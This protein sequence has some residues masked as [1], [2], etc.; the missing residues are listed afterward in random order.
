MTAESTEGIID[1]YAPGS[2]TPRSRRGA[3]RFAELPIAWAAF[4]FAAARHAGQYREID[5]APFIAHPVEV[6]QLLDC[7]GH[8]DEV[9][10]AGL[11]HDLLEKTGT[12]SA[13]LQR[14]F[15]TRIARLVESVT[16]DP[17]IDAYKSRKRELRDR[18]AHAR[19]DTLAIFAADKISKVRELALLPASHL[20]EPETV[21]KLAHYRASLT[22]LQ[23]VARDL[24]LVDVLATELNH[25]LTPAVTRNRGDGATQGITRANRRK[26]QT[27]T[28]SARGPGQPCGGA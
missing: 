17:S 10:A 6:G 19:P 12:T 26:P 14:R 28:T 16:D 18:V 4:E 3:G 20:R 2:A 9:I 24:T 8:P 11:L 7:D 22:M 27:R 23:Q 5:H 13:E 15:G 1:S 21:A 25:L